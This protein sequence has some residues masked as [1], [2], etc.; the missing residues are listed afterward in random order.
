[1]NN[2]RRR[3]QKGQAIVLIAFMMIILLGLLGLALDSGRGYVDR[4]ELQAAVDAAALAAGDSYENFA[5]PVAASQL[6]VQAFAEN[7]RIGNVGA[8]SYYSANPQ[9]YTFASDPTF[10]LVI[11]VANN[12]FAGTNFTMT[13]YHQIPLS[14][15]QVL[16]L[17]PTIQVST[18]ARSVVG[19][20]NSTPALLTCLLPDAIGV[21]CAVS[22]V[23]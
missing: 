18:I 3:A 8:P 13:A 1:M 19:N 21:S 22:D 7:E 4:R 14:I 20:Q 6:A 10:R 12:Q 16:G 11:G 23:R 17:G 9:N 2:R 5:D 15:M